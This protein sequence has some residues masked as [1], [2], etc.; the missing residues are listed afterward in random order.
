MLQIDDRLASYRIGAGEAWIMSVQM[1][2]M[3]GSAIIDWSTRRLVLS[4]YGPGRALVEQIEGVY[5]SDATGAYFAF[6]RD[7]R[8][9][10]SL[11]GKSVQVELAERLLEGRAVIATGPLTVA[12][13]SDGV[14]SFGSIIG[15]IDARFTFYF[16][17]TGLLSLIE[18]ELLPYAGVP[19]T[20]GPVIATPAGINSDGTPQV[21]ETL[22]GIDPTGNGP[23]VARRWIRSGATVATTQ[24]YTPTATGTLRFEADLQ[25]PDNTTATSGSDIVVQAAT[26]APTPVSITGTPPTTGT[27][28]QPYSF[29]P[30]T[31]GG[32]GTKVY[33]L[34]SGTLLAGLSLNTSTGAITGTPPAAGTMT[35]LSVRVTDDT[36]SAA[37]TPTTVTIAAAPSPSNQMT[38][39]GETVTAGGEP[40]TAGVY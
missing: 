22:T 21:G 36:G 18:Q 35:T 15:R 32:A 11:L 4:F 19:I 39:N 9:S 20:P 16:S 26:P 37:T 38:A 1:K 17:A 25:G 10:E 3:V 14:S 34:A 13:T 29:T 12:A 40:M 31:A 23:I 24:T 27:A 8:F 6:I 28:G 30:S 7:G 33:T 5:S 2:T